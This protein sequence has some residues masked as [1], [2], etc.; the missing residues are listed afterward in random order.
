MFWS[1]FAALF[2]V[3]STCIGLETVRCGGRY[4]TGRIQRS[5]YSYAGRFR[6]SD[7]GHLLESDPIILYGAPGTRILVLPRKVNGT[8]LTWK[9]Q[10]QYQ[11]FVKR[12]YRR[13]W[14]TNVTQFAGS[15]VWYDLTRNGT[16]VYT[17]AKGLVRV[18]SMT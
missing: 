1:M 11:G 18:G 4:C 6:Y 2:A 17:S 5:V 8:D 15:S 10:R 13:L 14:I 16:T 12:V 7:S 9:V 3:A